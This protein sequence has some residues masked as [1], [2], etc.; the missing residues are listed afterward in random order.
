MNSSDT[1]STTPAHRTLFSRRTLISKLTSP[2]ATKIRNVPDFHIQLPDD[3]RRYGPGDTVKG[4]VVVA[5]VK[6]VRVTHI[7]VCLHG[8]VRVLKT[9][10]LG[11]GALS[12]H[13]LIG[14]GRGNRGPE[15]LGNGLASIFELEKTLCG[16]GR[17]DV[18]Q[19]EFKFELPFPPTPLP[20]SLT[21]EKGTISYMVT[22]TLTR[23]TTINPVTT[24]DKRLHL[25]EHVDVGHLSPPKPRKISLKPIVSKVKSSK[26]ST[27]RGSAAS[28]SGVA[29]QAETDY[30]P[31]TASSISGRSSDEPTRQSPLPSAPSV[32]SSESAVPSEHGS[33]KWPAGIP[34]QSKKNTPRTST[35]SL[36]KKTITATI[37]MQR[38]GC[39]PGDILPLTITIDHTKP[40]R[41]MSG[42][43][44]TL[45]RQGRIDTYPV[46]PFPTA[47]GKAAVR[48]EDYYPLSRTGLGGLSLS[49]AGT[50]RTFRNEFSQSISPL[51]V[52]PDTLTAVVRP[53]VR[54]P[55]AA[56]PTI[57][58][59]PGAMISFKYYVE[60]VVD[61]GGKFSSLLP[62]LGMIHGPT[63]MGH[64][65]AEP[66]GAFEDASGGLQ[67]TFGGVIVDTAPL[68]RERSVVSWTFEAIV[69]TVDSTRGRAVRRPEGTSSLPTSPSIPDS[70]S[71]DHLRPGHLT[72]NTISAPPTADPNSHLQN[73]TS[74]TI[75]Y[76]YG[77]QPP[78]PYSDPPVPAPEV[79]ADSALTEK[80]RI[81]L[82][83]ERALPSSP[84]QS[85]SSSNQIAPSAPV[86]D[87]L[88]PDPPQTAI[89]HARRSFGP[90]APTID[91]VLHNSHPPQA[92]D[93]K[94]EL[95]RR[96]L[97]N[98]ASRPGDFPDDE[99][100]VPPGP[101]APPVLITGPSAPVMDPDEDFEDHRI[102]L[103][104]SEGLPRYER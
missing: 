73:G 28:D 24:R 40:I 7:V 76:F 18:G 89:R 91:G 53:S 84:P 67:A 80:A 1:S 10:A 88:D 16:D 39:L 49:A 100:G 82:A 102:L 52:D 2:F 6:P 37:E 23:P 34:G 29:S 51:L 78:F 86:M 22:A 3:L 90:T 70:L 96:R 58:S 87:G 66:P 17:L 98:E 26:S 15:Y 61:L 63:N 38:A 55:V 81:Q 13:G 30:I 9:G 94:A 59:V 93:D 36:A 11:E 25:T 65:S 12:D 32:V 42:V 79:L 50:C 5:I 20:T 69:G 35:T 92:T 56:F 77:S 8:F 21:F 31:E 46:V 41:S 60:V 71:N 44:V 27:V 62:R 19:Y 99:D 33:F 103:E 45:Y 97:E 64:A 95:E 104:G 57:S 101:S 43:I 14:S 74:D 68:R 72:P 75:D 4:T 83:E 85:A 54:I 47:K 48:H